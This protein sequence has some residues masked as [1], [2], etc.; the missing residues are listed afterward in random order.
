MSSALVA[1][2]ALAAALRAAAAVPPAA[3]APAP[4]GA[5]ARAV[6]IAAPDGLVLHGTYY[7]AARHTGR[8]VLLLH[9]MCGNREAWAPFRG[10]LAAAGVDA[11]AVDL[12]G[13]GETGGK[14]E[15]KDEV[16]DAR[17][18]L[19]WLAA[20]PGVEKIGVAGESLG[21]KLTLT[22]CARE[23]R[24]RVAAA[25]S[26]YGSYTESELDFTDR[27][28]YLVGVRGD[29]VKSALAVR[30][31]AADVKGDVTLRLVAGIEPGIASVLEGSLVSEVVAWV[32]HHLGAVD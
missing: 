5:A 17:A 20:Q 12:R 14:M 18:W 25:L 2:A 4:D 10:L 31:M 16:A 6:S 21:A 8:A 1:A 22:I 9:E 29:D 32:D 27:A 19:A 23:A 24:C 11:L 15:W 3:T 30:R 26:P 7:P 28:V 13:F